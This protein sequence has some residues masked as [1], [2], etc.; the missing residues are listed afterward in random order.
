MRTVRLGSLGTLESHGR[1]SP[2]LLEVYR[3]GLVSM[4]TSIGE[5]RPRDASGEYLWIQ[6]GAGEHPG[7][8]TLKT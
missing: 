7:T 8:R 4:P 3:V 2:A 5:P 6:G 1:S